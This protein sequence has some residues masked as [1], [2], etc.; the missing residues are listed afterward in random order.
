[1][2]DR[3][4]TL[5]GG[6]NLGGRGLAGGGGGEGARGAAC[7]VDD[8]GL[9]AQGGAGRGLGVEVLGDLVGGVVGGAEDLPLL[10]AGL[11]GE[12]DAAEAAAADV[13]GELDGAGG[14]GGRGLQ[15]Q[16]GLDGRLGGGRHGLEDHGGEGGDGDG[17]LAGRRGTDQRGAA[18]QGAVLGAGRGVDLDGAGCGAVVG[19]DQVLGA[20]LGVGAGEGVD[21]AV[22]ETFALDAVAEGRVRLRQLGES[23]DLLVERVS[24]I[25]SIARVR[26]H[27]SELVVVQVV[28]D[29]RG[30]QRLPG[31]LVA[32]GAR[33]ALLVTGVDHRVAPGEEHQLVGQPVALQQFLLAGPRPV[34]LQE[35]GEAAHVVVAEEGHLLVGVGLA[36]GVPV[37]V[38]EDGG[39]PAGR[40]ALG[41]VRADRVLEREVEGGVELPAGHVRGGDGGVG[42]VDLAEHEEVVTAALRGV[43]VEGG[44]P[45]RPEPGVDV[46][47][48]VDP[49]AV[50]VEVPHPLLVDLL[51]PADDLGTLGP[52]V[53]EAEEVALVGGLAGE[54]GV[55]AVVVHRRVVEP[56]RHLEVLLRVGHEGRPREGRAVH[57]REL[58][59]PVGVVLVVEGHPV[60]RQIGERPLRQVRVRRLPVVHDIGGVVGDDV[61]EDLHPLPVRLV[62]QPLQV[63][64]RPEVRVDLREV[65]DP[66]AVVAGGDI[67]PLA[68]HRLVLEDRRQP[69]GRGAEPL[70]VVEP[71]GE[72]LEVTALVEA[73]VGGVQAGLQAR[74]GQAAPVVARVTVREPVRE[75]EVELFPGQVV[76][77]RFGG[78]FRVRGRGGRRPARRGRGGE[79]GQERHGQ[80]G[81][82]HSCGRAYQGRSPCV[83]VAWMRTAR[84]GREDG[85]GRPWS[86]ERRLSCA[87]CRSA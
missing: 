8:D 21:G 67:G 52:Q 84:P 77:G 72:A 78:Q 69:D 79:G 25:V 87:R 36:G 32:A 35:G 58:R 7:G 50:D 16:G 64:V 6:R 73:L 66:V 19:G 13:G 39:Q 31:V 86:T 68:L 46:L 47:D 14:A 57:L 20:G 40:R 81:G 30:E 11:G 43:G 44:R 54:G 83:R 63:G 2:D 56:A 4:V 38:A 51:H 62:D 26:A 15:G 42:G 65:G 61:E 18:V 3:V 17:E 85:A 70:D 49:E 45:L 37:V 9:V 80:G 24:R 74:A 27:R 34:L 41:G 1:M 5:G 12:D 28:G 71:V 53:V 22:G 75:H 23:T 29:L 60:L 48:R 55:P 82:E 76:V 10:V 59:L 33:E